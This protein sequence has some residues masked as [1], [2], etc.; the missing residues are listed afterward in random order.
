MSPIAKIQYVKGDAT[1]PFSSGPAII[2]HICNDIGKWGKG[3]VLAI[4]GRWKRP[5]AE[6]RSWHGQPS[7]ALG[8][9]QLIEVAPALWVSSMIAQHGIRSAVNPSPFR[10]DALKKCLGALATVATTRSA[11]VHMPRIG[12]GL[13]GGTWEQIEPVVDEYL[14]ATGVHVTVYDYKAR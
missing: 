1:A 13:A 2:A 7:F 10:R 9:I 6:Y 4:S 3:F 14:A 5:E 8:K 11:G 12:C